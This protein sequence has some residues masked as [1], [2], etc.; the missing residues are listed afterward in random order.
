MRWTSIAE[1]SE[2]IPLPAGYAFRQLRREDV[3]ELAAKVRQWHPDIVVGAGSCYVREAFYLDKTCLAGE[4]ERDIYVLLIECAGELAGMWSFEREDD[5]LSIYGRILIVAPEH[6]GSKVAVSCMLGTER[7]C[8]AC[9]AEFVYTMATLKTPHM[10]MALERA[11]YQLVGF[12]PGYDREVGRDGL[13]KRVYEAVFGK[14]LVSDAEM[15]RPDPANL[16]P[17]TRALFELMFPPAA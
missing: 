11:G 15:L 6:R 7:V 5:A 8:R 3:P 13:V 4:A 9:G 17:R 12:A 14:I 10:Q 1:T 16:T 2:L